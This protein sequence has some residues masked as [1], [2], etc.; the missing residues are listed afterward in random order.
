MSRTDLPPQ[1]TF[2][3]TVAAD[4]LPEAIYTILG[5]A[6]GDAEHAALIRYA[7]AHGLGLFDGPRINVTVAE[8]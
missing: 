2:R 1:K 8:A 5:A 6:P 4:G 3:V 7:Q